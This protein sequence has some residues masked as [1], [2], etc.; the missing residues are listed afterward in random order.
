MVENDVVKSYKAEIDKPLADL[1]Q[2]KVAEIRDIMKDMSMDGI[3]IGISPSDVTLDKY[4]RGEITN[5]IRNMFKRMRASD[6][7]GLS[8]TLILVGEYSPV[9][10]WHYHGVLKVKNIKIVERIRKKLNTLIGRTVTEQIRNT[11]LY[12]DY[13]FKQYIADDMDYYMWDSKECYINISRD[14]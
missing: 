2:K 14:K 5:M 11:E 6:G 10:R 3:S 7:Q 1:R 13:M 4:E 8:L 12:K 9:H